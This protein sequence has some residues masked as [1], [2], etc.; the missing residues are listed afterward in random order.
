[1]Q[2]KLTFCIALALLFCFVN[3]AYSQTLR[4]TGRVIEKRSGDPLPGATVAIKG[5][6][7]GT[8]TD[9]NG[10]YVLQI[11]QGGATLV[12]SF[13]G[14]NKIEQQVNQAGEVNF[15]LE[16]NAS[17]TLNEVVVV[18][19]GT[20]KVTNISGAISVVKASDIKKLTPLRA[21][22]ALQG[23]ASGVT[24]IQSG[25]PGSKPTVQVRGIP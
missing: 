18:G 19:Y 24:V 21:E 16:D 14:M 1:M 15:A 17:N 22:E 11:P 9:I 8:V 25:S 6:T 3:R 10:K 7:N 5:S 4:V 23:Q 13:I 12:V 2:K 20:Q